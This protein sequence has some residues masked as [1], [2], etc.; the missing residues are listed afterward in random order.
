MMERYALRAADDSK[1]IALD[2]FT[3]ISTVIHNLKL[4]IC[5]DN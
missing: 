1:P 4:T 2:L 5:K 3:N